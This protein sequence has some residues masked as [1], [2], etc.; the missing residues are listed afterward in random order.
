MDDNKIRV[1][2]ASSDNLCI[3][4]HFGRAENFCIADIYGNGSVI[5]VEERKVV[6]VCGMGQHDDGELKNAVEALSDC[7]VVLAVRIGFGAA[8]ELEE[9]GITPLE[10]SGMIDESLQKLSSY[11]NKF[12][13]RGE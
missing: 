8:R 7:D 11:I 3:N 12:K 4:R 1:A 10:V 6:P 13:K 5:R 2:A 9:N